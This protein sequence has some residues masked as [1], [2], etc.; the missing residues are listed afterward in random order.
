VIDRFR[1]L[2]LPRRH[3]RP[4]LLSRYLDDDLDAGARRAVEAHVRGCARCRDLLGSLASAV[5]A[6]GSMGRQSSP[7]LADSIIAA[8]RAEGPPEAIQRPARDGVGLP[9]LTIVRGTEHPARSHGIS[10]A[11]PGAIR[12]AVRYCLRRPQLRLTIPI[13]L[14]TGVVLSLVNMGGMLLRGRIDLG[15]C[16]S[17]AMDFLV[18]FVALNLG[19]LLLLR[20]PGRRRL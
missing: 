13:A 14:V 17:C 18:P 7:G 20:I 5:A 6:L 3:P 10:R 8:V 1:S 15:V 19:L 2:P 9:A 4:E 16:V 11:W 12:A